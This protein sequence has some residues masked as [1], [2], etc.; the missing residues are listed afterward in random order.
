MQTF[1]FPYKH[2]IPKNHVIVPKVK[3]LKK[4]GKFVIAEVNSECCNNGQYWPSWAAL[5]HR[6]CGVFVYPPP[7][8]Q[9][10]KTIAICTFIYKTCT[11]TVH[12]EWY[13]NENQWTVYVFIWHIGMYLP[14]CVSI[15]V[16]IM[17]VSHGFNQN[18]LTP[19]DMYYK[20]YPGQSWGV[21]TFGDFKLSIVVIKYMKYI[22]MFIMFIIQIR[23]HKM[24]FTNIAHFYF[25]LCWHT[26]LFIC[27]KR[28]AWYEFCAFASDHINIWW[29][30]KINKDNLWLCSVYHKFHESSL[31]G[32]GMF[33]SSVIN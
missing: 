17:R 12:R 25:W 19:S 8:F 15:F 7:P 16:V 33:Y 14:F 13:M 1:H 30:T 18:S 26:F 9:T 21:M 22:D 32:I 10:T 4:L 20:C 23:W 11:L 29:M 24:M 5:L 27:N 2:G 3:I 6:L 31:R 28:R